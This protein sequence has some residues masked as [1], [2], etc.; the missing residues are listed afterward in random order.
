MNGM[1]N[2]KRKQSKKKKKKKNDCEKGPSRDSAN[3]KIK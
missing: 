1:I 2:N 3:R